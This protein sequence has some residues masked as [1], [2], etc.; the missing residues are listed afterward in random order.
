MVLRLGSRWTV[1][2][3]HQYVAGGPDPLVEDRIR[4]GPLLHPNLLGGHHTTLSGQR[5][6]FQPR[7]LNPTLKPP[8]PPTSFHVF[9]HHPICP[10][11]CPGAEALVVEEGA[12]LLLLGEGGHPLVLPVAAWLRPLRYQ[13]ADRV[14]G[15]G[16]D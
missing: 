10:D 13:P 6:P 16:P 9:I 15:Q 14:E 7:A 2:S 1:C 4:K 11:L 5:V 12:E 8:S 3:T